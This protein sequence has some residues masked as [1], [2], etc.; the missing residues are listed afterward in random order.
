MTREE[1]ALQLALKVIG[2]CKPSD[3][4]DE[5]LNMDTEKVSTLYKHI[6]NSLDEKAGSP[7]D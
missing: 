2:Q 3:L 4:I 1:I 7:P 6:L 5:V